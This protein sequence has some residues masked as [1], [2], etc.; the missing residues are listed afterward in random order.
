M[1]EAHEGLITAIFS[2]ADMLELPVGA[3]DDMAKMAVRAVPGC[4]GASVSVLE[5]DGQVTTAGASDERTIQLDKLQYHIQQGPYLSAIRTAATIQV[6]DFACDS[7]YPTFGPAAAALGVACCLSV[8]LT[9]SHQ[10]VGVLNLYGDVPH[11]YSEP[12]VATAE[13]AAAHAA[14]LIATSRAHH[15]SLDLA[16][17][18]QVA[19]AARAEIEQAKGILMAGSHC[20]ADQ[21]FDI[22]RRASQRGNLKLR[23]IAH[24]IVADT[25][26]LARTADRPTLPQQLRLGG[27]GQAGLQPRSIGTARAG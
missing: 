10:T 9:A 14:L 21:A 23:D 5:A 7:R 26:N 12:A 24:A 2:L 1:A 17:K 27:R 3:F 15:R 4:D 25:S 8:P 18:H 11:A 13:T 19:L 6:D 20:G 16:D 22:L